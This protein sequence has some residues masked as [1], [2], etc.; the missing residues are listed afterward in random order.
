MG[1]LAF[2]LFI[3]CWREDLVIHEVCHEVKTVAGYFTDTGFVYE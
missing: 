2:G 1:G 3:L